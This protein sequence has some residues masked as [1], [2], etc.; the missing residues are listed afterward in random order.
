MYINQEKRRLLH[1]FFYHGV[2]YRIKEKI[3]IRKSIFSLPPGEGVGADALLYVP[4]PDR[5]VEAGR[6]QHQGH[7]RVIRPRS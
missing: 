1:I 4:E 2:F 7:V 3:H 6:G 5:G